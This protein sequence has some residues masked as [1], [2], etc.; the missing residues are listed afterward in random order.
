MKI[1]RGQLERDL[2]QPRQ[3]TYVE[4]FF[5]L[6][7]I[8]IFFRLAQSLL[9]RLTWV[10]AYQTL[11]LLLAVWWVWAYTNLVTDTLDSRRLRLQL[12]VIGTMFGSLLLSTT[13][14]E[15]FEQ[16]AL[17]FAITYVAVNLGRSTGMA[18]LLYGHP[19]SRRPMRGAIWFAF[20]AIF[21]L[22]GA[23]SEDER[24]LVLWGIAILIDYFAAFAGWPTPKL[25]RT[26][27][28]EWNLAGEHIAER[29]RQFTIIALGETVAVTG[30]TLHESD[31]TPHRVV[32]FAL[33]FATSAL[34]Y[35]TYF[36]RTRERLGTPFSGAA[37]PANR[38]KLAGFAHLLMAAGVVL[39][40]VADQ[41]VISNPT[42]SAR[43]SWV[44]VI[45]G[46]PAL[47]L[48]G[49]VLLGRKVFVRVTRPRLIGAG[50]LIAA[51]PALVSLP[52]LAVVA[53]VIVVLTAIVC[54]ELALPRD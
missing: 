48:V 30:R 31:F 22:T 41:L 36:H 17:L 23:L 29:Y 26:G 38:T 4:L 32:A 27:A 24:R 40:T 47:F 18:I 16:R 33:A 42:A 25:G 3:S 53:V 10:G 7:Y 20:S 2:R 15:A 9:D 46:G 8:F 5:D 43:T 52:A 6:I 13:I 19:L 28:G 44:A 39:I 35:W 49:H 45:V 14:P 12:L 11:I 50:V 1:G 34:L 51:G 54:Y 21:W 37:E